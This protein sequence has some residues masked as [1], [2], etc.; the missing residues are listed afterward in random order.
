M[1]KGHAAT[2]C[3]LKPAIH[4]YAFGMHWFGWGGKIFGSKLHI[5]ILHA[6]VCQQF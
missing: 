5:L 4:M 2:Y 1:I 3:V 6:I